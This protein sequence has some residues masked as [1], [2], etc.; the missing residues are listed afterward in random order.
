[1]NSTSQLAEF[2]SKT[3]YEDIPE[4]VIEGMKA[5]V[6][7]WLGSALSGKSFYPSNLF[8]HYANLMG[9]KDGSSTIF[10]SDQ[11]SSPY[12]A[13]LVN[14]A[15]SHLLE[16]DDLHNS[17]VFHPAT[18][19]F[20]AILAA[21]E[22]LSISGKDFLLAAVMGYE[23]GIRIGEFL[24]RTH[25]QVFHTTSTVGSLSAA[26]AVGKLMQFNKEQ[27]LNLIGSA[28]TQS[29]G[30]W[31]FLEDAADSKQLH[32]A[33]ANA[34]G[35]L[36][37][38]MT[39]EGL[40]GAKNALESLQGLAR[41]MS[42]DQDEKYLSDQLGDRWA[43]IETSFKYH[44]SCR[45]THPA[46]DALLKLLEEYRLSYK[47]IT[48]IEAHVHQAAIDVLGPV[49]N[50]QTIHQAKFSMGTVIGLLAVHGKAG[51]FEF[52]Q[53]ALT[54]REVL[55]IKD[56]V[57]MIL[58]LDIDQAYPKEWQGKVIVETDDGNRYEMFLRYPKGDPENPLT[59]EELEEKFKKLLH[60]SG[61]ELL[62]SKSRELMDLIWCLDQLPTLERLT[63]L[64]T[65]NN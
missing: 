29:A 19:V 7:D 3:R 17:S 31:A 2:L 12:F 36:A 4:S 13:A 8:R 58:D 50:P 21:G 46:G 43:S 52:A 57:S 33:K 37:A 5:L 56:K 24:G 25:Y 10:G 49:E 59:H 44:A 45:H 48:K 26:I 30:L 64:L 22:E 20:P 62:L 65:H 6:L 47:K 16:Q 38:Y 18:V 34:N 14:G 1:M 54:D 39:R 35:V 60:F 23:A 27:M 9:P 55:A 32:T 53:Y 28:A 42:Q 15:S 61:D 63:N 41:G 51:L 40:T 11:K